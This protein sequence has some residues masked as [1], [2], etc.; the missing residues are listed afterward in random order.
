M[1]LV[2]SSSTESQYTTTAFLKEALFGATATSTAEDGYL[3]RLITRASR[4]AERYIGQP[5]PDNKGDSLSPQVYLEAVPAFEGRNL[6]LSRT[7]VRAIQRLFDSTATSGA[8]A[9]NSSQYRIED[10]DAGLVSFTDDSLPVW[11]GITAWELTDYRVPRSEAR[12]WLVEYE[13]GWA[14]A[15]TTSTFGGTT[16]TGRTLPEDVEQAVI[17][18]AVE[19]YEGRGRIASKRVGDLSLSYREDGDSPAERLLCPYRR[20][21]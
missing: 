18:K 9:Y 7:P 11:T 14:V 8:T 17:E 15:G 12:P 6:V 21:A 20:V 10:A 19:L 16:S 3:D 4:W 1:L 13:A 2:C 5:A